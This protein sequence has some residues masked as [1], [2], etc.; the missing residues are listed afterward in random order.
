MN[1]INIINIINEY[2]KSIVY[3]TSVQNIYI[4]SI[5][6]DEPVSII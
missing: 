6:C 4:L 5:N 3:Y 1:I 2:N